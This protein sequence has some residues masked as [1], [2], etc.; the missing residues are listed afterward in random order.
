MTKTTQQLDPAETKAEQ[1]RL[2][3]EIESRKV[4]YI[5]SPDFRK[6]NADAKILGE[7]EQADSPKRRRNKRPD[8]IPAYFASLYET[9]LLTADEEADLF[10][11]FNYLKYRAEK[12]RIGLVSKGYDADV[13]WQIDS[14]MASAHEV[15]NELVQANLRLVVSIARRFVDNA[16]TFDDLVSDGQVA[17]MNAIEKFDYTRGFRFSTYATH[18]IQRTYYRR[19]KKKQRES[20]RL[21]H[22]STDLM[23]EMPDDS[24]SVEEEHADMTQIRNLHALISSELDEREQLILCA[25]Y[26]L[27][28]EMESATLRAI[29]QRLGISKE[30]VRQIQI[31]AIEKL[32]EQFH[33][34]GN[35]V[36]A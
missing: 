35:T 23:E 16:H 12:L 7:R 31:R 11:R 2:N 3:R 19:I 32:Q 36:T 1:E 33:S 25:R 10:R 8:N 18:A 22:A 9:P 26:G 21:L 17:L 6:R 15:W 14:L 5:D 27:G 28:D 34:T 30:R 4:S 13:I 24:D 29:G 20:V